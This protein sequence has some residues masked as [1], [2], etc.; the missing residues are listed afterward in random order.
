M[1]DNLLDPRI[2]FVKKKYRSLARLIAFSSGKGGVGKSTLSALSAMYMASKGYRVGLLDLDLYGPSTHVILN[3]DIHT[4]P[5][6]ESGV[7]PP[8]VNGVYFM[9]VVYYS[10]N[11]PLVMRGGDLRNAVMELLTII[12]WPSLDYLIID[13][14]P[15]LGDTLL[16]IAEFIPASFVVVTNPTKIAMESVEK[17]VDFLKTQNLS[18]SGIVE[19]MKTKDSSFVKS[20]ADSLNIKYLGSIGFYPDIEDLY[21]NPDKIAGSEISRELEMVLKKGI[22]I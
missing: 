17:L 1:S 21:G 5:E 9:S 19:N 11:K 20:K 8:L 15:G 18:V 14:P 10:E 3:A 6:E 22:G 16:D 7:V 13:M 12:N 4:L 2:N